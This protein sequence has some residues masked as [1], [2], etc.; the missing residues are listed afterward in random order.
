MRAKKLVDAE[1]QAHSHWDTEVRGYSKENYDLVQFG[2]FWRISDYL[3]GSGAVGINLVFRTSISKHRTVS[4]RGTIW[5]QRLNSYQVYSGSRA[6][7]RIGLDSSIC[8]GPPISISKPGD[9]VTNWSWQFQW[10][11]AAA[12]IFFIC[13]FLVESGYARTLPSKSNG[14]NMATMAWTPP[15]IRGW[16]RHH[17]QAGNSVYHRC[18]LL[19]RSKFV[20]TCTCYRCNINFLFE[21]LRSSLTID[22]AWYWLKQ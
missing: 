14:K 6:S 19:K 4:Y 12:H 22:F 18:N 5:R 15:S 10:R 13:K 9:M 7:R 11:R 3:L 2:T 8:G 20:Y 16:F 17:C 21:F 1:T